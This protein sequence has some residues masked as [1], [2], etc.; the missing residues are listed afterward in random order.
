MPPK[1]KR[2]QQANE[3][4]GV[5]SGIPSSVAW[6]YSVNAKYHQLLQAIIK[7]IEGHELTKFQWLTS[8][9]L[10]ITEGGGQAPFSQKD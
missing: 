4:G 10:K 5:D 7:R 3:G 8:K 2:K 9:P 1:K 6:I